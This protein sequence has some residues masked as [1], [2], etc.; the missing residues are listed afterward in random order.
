L[1]DSFINPE[2][3]SNLLCQH[4]TFSELQGIKTQ[5]TFT[6]LVIVG[7]LPSELKTNIGMDMEEWLLE[8]FMSIVQCSP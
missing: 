2:D 3:G 4:V 8:R 5:K 6:F 1:L 7:C